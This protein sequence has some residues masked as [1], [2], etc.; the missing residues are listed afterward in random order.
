M[1]GL[2]NSCA[3]ISLSDAPA[4]PAVRRGRLEVLL[5]V[6]RLYLARQ[7]GD[8]PAV[9]DAA[10]G[11]L[12]AVDTPDEPRLSLGE[13]LR[14]LT[15]ISLGVAEVWAFRFIDANQHLEQGVALARRIRRPCRCRSTRSARISAMCAASWT[16]TVGRRR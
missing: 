5:T 1:L 3:A 6:L 12:A 16:R 9:S 4:A 2:M 13:D 10:D 14:A 15:L 11:L 8:L 7:R